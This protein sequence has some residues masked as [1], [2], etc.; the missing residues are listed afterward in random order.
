M[1]DGHVIAYASQ[2]LRK[3]EEHCPTYNLELAVM[4]HTLEIW[5]HYLMEK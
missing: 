1:Q 3:H 2:Q 5:T 4:V